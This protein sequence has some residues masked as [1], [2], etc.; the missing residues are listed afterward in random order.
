MRY[1]F[2]IYA[3][4]VVLVISI[5]GFRGEKFKQSPIRIFPD[6]DEQDRVNYQAKSDFFHDGMGSRQPVDKTVPQGLKPIS[7][8]GEVQADGFTNDV[9]YFQTGMID[10][11]FFGQGLP[12][13]EL[14][15]TEETAEAFLKHGATTFDVHCSRCHGESGNGKGVLHEYGLPGIA[16][17]VTTKLSDGAI[18]NIITNG[19]GN[20]GH[21]K[22]N[23]DLHDR[24]AAVAYIRTLQYSRSVPK[25]LLESADATETK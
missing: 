16:N 12:V 9:T 19:R 21:F 14:G 2:L 13:K 4:V 8:A 18:F 20:M 7:E 22:H 10:E 1:F 11:Q 15:L 23:L 6:M 3:L 24:W 25:D 17:L 5:F